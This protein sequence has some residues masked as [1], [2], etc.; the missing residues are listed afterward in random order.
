MDDIMFSW[1]SNRSVTMEGGLMLPQFTIDGANQANKTV[2]L[3]TG[4]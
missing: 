1:Q 4:K 2:T 3:T